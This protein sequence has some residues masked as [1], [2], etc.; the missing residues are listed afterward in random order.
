[1]KA[2]SASA[3]DRLYILS[4]KLTRY[5]LNELSKISNNYPTANSI[6]PLIMFPLANSTG[7][8]CPHRVLLQRKRGAKIPVS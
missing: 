1:M 5:K 3:D 4:S 8:Y 6:L 7:Q 2:V